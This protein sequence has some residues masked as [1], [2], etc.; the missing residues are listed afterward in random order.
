MRHLLLFIFLLPVTYLWAQDVTDIIS[1]KYDKVVIYFKENKMGFANDVMLS[2][3]AVRA[4]YHCIKIEFTYAPYI[5]SAANIFLDEPTDSI[6]DSTTDTQKHVSFLVVDFISKEK[7]V[8]SVSFGYNLVY[9]RNNG[10]NG[11][12][13]A[14]SE[15]MIKWL[16][17]NTNPNWVDIP[18]WKNAVLKNM[19]TINV[20]Q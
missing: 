11:M 20:T 2:P 9:I 14:P 17:E 12:W 3:Y 6:V 19:R 18:F 16:D 7:I 8:K 13:Y 1:L 4:N 10:L 5:L 15:K